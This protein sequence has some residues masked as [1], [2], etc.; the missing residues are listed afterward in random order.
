[1]TTVE[2]KKRYELISAREKTKL[3]QQEVAE[4]VGVTQANISRYE[5]G[6][7]SPAI[8]VAFKL[9]ELYK[10]DVSTLFNK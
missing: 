7:Q 3:S 9:A 1:M 2:R 8:S 5:N 6:T 10:K 4:I